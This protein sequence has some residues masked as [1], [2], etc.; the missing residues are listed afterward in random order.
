M[1]FYEACTNISQCA[2]GH[3]DLSAID[4][5]LGLRFDVYEVR[6]HIDRRQIEG[7]NNI[8]VLSH[9]EQR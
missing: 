7:K 9:Y 8:K 3:H 6:I 1:S 5:V 2:V 4:G